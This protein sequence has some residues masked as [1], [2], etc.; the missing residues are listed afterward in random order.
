MKKRGGVGRGNAMKERVGND[1]KK[2]R[3][4]II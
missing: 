3:V 4:G 1:M 2:R